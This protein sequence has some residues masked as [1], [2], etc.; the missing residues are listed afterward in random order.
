MKG[1]FTEKTRGLIKDRARGF[2]ERCARPLREFAQI[3]HR[4]PRGMGGT[5]DDSLA[6]PANGLWL[7]FRCHQWVES[8]RSEAVRMGWIVPRGQLPHETPVLTSWGWTL[9]D[10]NGSSAPCEPPAS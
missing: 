10:E 7:C 6:S 8:H 1:K 9:L 4:T 5:S 2:C 3:H